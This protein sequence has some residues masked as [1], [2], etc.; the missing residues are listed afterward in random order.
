M[1][2]TG[3]LRRALRM[4][5]SSLSCGEHELWLRLRFDRSLRG[6]FD[7]AAY[8]A[9]LS[10][11]GGFGLPQMLPPLGVGLGMEPPGG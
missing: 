8:A 2:G 1:C 7:S 9:T 11:N 3:P 5:R 6:C 4:S 10:T